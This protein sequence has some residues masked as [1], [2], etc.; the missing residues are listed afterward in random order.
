MKAKNAGKPR[1]PAGVPLTEGLR[2]PDTPAK[3][4]PEPP[5]PFSPLGSRLPWFR[6]LAFP[7]VITEKLYGLGITHTQLLATHLPHRYEDLSRIIALKDA[8]AGE[9]AQFE[10]VV[11]SM[12]SR[13]V[14]KRQSHM[15]QVTD[16]TAEAIVRFYNLYPAQIQ[17]LQPGARLRIYGEMKL[18]Y[19][20]RELHHPRWSLAERAP[21]IQA[22]LSPVYPLTT[23]LNQHTLCRQINRVLEKMPEELLPMDIATSHHYPRLKDALQ[24]LHHPPADLP[25]EVVTSPRYPPR[26]RCKRDELLALQLILLRVRAHTQRH[27]AHPLP[28][29]SSQ[30]LCDRLLTSLPFQLT[31]A[32][33]RVWQ[34]VQSD[35]ASPHPMARLLQGDVGS[36]KTIVA[37]L[38]C[39]RALEHRHQAVVMAPTEILA[40]QHYLR[41]TQ[42]LRPFGINVG[43]LAS[44]VSNKEKQQLASLVKQ[45][46]INLV[47]GTHALIEDTIEFPSLAV[48]VID[49]Q[50]RFGVKQ[51]IQL[52]ERQENPHPYQSAPLPHQLMMSA[53]PIPRTLAMS[54]YA[55]LEL[56]VIDELPA[57]RQVIRT[58]LVNH[59]RRAAI[60]HFIEK[61][62][63]QGQQVYWICPLIE[64]S[65]VLQLQTAT[66]TLERLKKDLP[67]WS[68]AMGILNG[69]MNAEEKQRAM[70]D[71]SANR[72]A[73]LVSTTVVEVGVDVPNACV[74]VIENAERFGLAQL[75]QLRGRVGRGNA[76]SVCILLFQEPLTEDAKARLKVMF[77]QTDGFKIAAEDL[78]IRGPGEMVGDRQSGIPTLR[79]A[80]LAEDL[81]L[82]KE[83][84]HLAP[85][86]LLEYPDYVDAIIEFW[87]PTA[88]EH[89]RYYRA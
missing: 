88:R 83:A 24:S 71:F 41:F 28:V 36:G 72:I 22:A 54:H 35:L 74:M 87:M 11:R 57:G 89:E 25:M 30:N 27:H 64:E 19:T 77:E 18:E 60:Y 69:R 81:H 62:L 12:Q 82:L 67:S 58:R 55:H 23:G 73:L 75:H 38:A 26:Q 8:V 6:S 32:Q 48:A 61:T 43:W 10:V 52:Q 68:A 1:N 15:M 7:R 59:E 79:F 44:S 31:R 86:L 47:V 51:R 45:R 2:S 46:V 50:H 5:P 16:G 53:T 13:G 9:S 3:T 34:E 29:E 40:E 56:S 20:T 66:S 76:E 85:I 65:E 78:R 80:N 14:G 70:A 84:R 17:L 49:E 39:C 63:S 33:K 21:P 42:L 37:L 4:T